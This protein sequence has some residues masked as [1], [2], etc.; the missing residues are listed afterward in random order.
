MSKSNSR[1]FDFLKINLLTPQSIY[2]SLIFDSFCEFLSAQ[3]QYQQAIQF[4]LQ[5]PKL[6]PL[7][8]PGGFHPQHTHALTYSKI[9]V[10]GLKRDTERKSL[11]RYFNK[12][13]SI[14]RV[15][16]VM[17]PR[18]PSKNRGFA[19]VQ[20]EHIEGCERACRKGQFHSI[21]GHDVEVKRAVLKP[22]GSGNET[23][24]IDPTAYGYGMMQQYYQ[25]G[26]PNQSQ[27]QGQN[28]GQNVSQISGNNNPAT[29]STSN[30]DTQSNSETNSR[31]N[32]LSQP[33]SLH[34]MQNN[35]NY[36]NLNSSS[37]TNFSSQ[38]SMAG[39]P[40]AIPNNNPQN[41]MIPA[42][43]IY[44]NLNSSGASNQNANHATNA[45]GLKAGENAQN[46]TGNTDN[47]NNANTHVNATTKT[48]SANDENKTIHITDDEDEIQAGADYT[49]MK[50]HVGAGKL[51]GKNA[52]GSNYSNNDQN[53]DS[54]MMTNQ[55]SQNS[56]SPIGGKNGSLSQPNNQGQ[57]YAGYEA[58][59]YGDGSNFGYIN[60]GYAYGGYDYWIFEGNCVRAR[61]IP[62]YPN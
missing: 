56:V 52:S 26:V 16:L 23:A 14:K 28:G 15:D 35:S 40:I 39:T 46:G 58:Y 55:N 13:G 8:W 20:F 7:E 54:G 53:K 38:N 36:V 17:D 24:G 31:N 42:S 22:P 18:N 11:V 27:G 4:A 21:D 37:Q 57:Y 62:E 9:F 43:T 50:T 10:G 12:F 61:D 1:P 41:Y 45:A 32:Q 49:N 34:Q 2:F 30:M 6:G 3:Q 19:F 51:A 5:N 33:N 25:G 59:N 44:P 29:A 48:S 60:Q 47:E